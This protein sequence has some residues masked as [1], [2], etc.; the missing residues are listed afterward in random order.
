MNIASASKQE[1]VHKT[2]RLAPSTITGIEKTA[3]DFG[4]NFTR[5][6]EQLIR[7]GLLHANDYSVEVDVEIQRVVIEQAVSRALNRYLKILSQ[8]VIAAN[9]AKEMAQQVF[10]AQLCM[11]SNDLYDAEDV[12]EALT[13]HSWKPLHEKLHETYEQRRVR[14]RQRAIEQL[15][16][17][18]ELDEEAWETVTKWGKRK[19]TESDDVTSRL[20]AEAVE[21]KLN[22]HLELL[23]QTVI[24][25]NEAKEM[26][27]QVFFTQLRQLADDLKDPSEVRR[28]LALD[29]RDP[30]HSALYDLYKQRQ[31]RGRNRAVRELKS[32]ID[33]DAW[34]KLMQRIEEAT[35]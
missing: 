5:T 21:R 9:E 30:L 29:S 3:D 34:Q 8:T 18:I 10:F 28:A 33:I 23:T 20:I 15:T 24:A 7:W 4:F 12:D 26:A 1:R 11:L 27:Q 22:R 19:T 35:A 17:G 16:K 14:G 32:A 2:M 13:L 31:A 6:V 25:A